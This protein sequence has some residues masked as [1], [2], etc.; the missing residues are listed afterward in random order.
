MLDWL[1]Q[2][3]GP[4]LTLDK[5]TY[6]GNLENLASVENDPRHVFVQG[7]IG[8]SPLLAQLLAQ[9]QPRAVLN[10]ATTTARCISRRSSFLS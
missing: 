2:S 6:A 5:L 4:V 3:E 9:Y 7:D 8:D 10:A 1:A